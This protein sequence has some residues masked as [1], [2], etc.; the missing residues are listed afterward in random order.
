MSSLS[1]TSCLSLFLTILLPAGIRAQSQF[2]RDDSLVENRAYY[3]A[4]S[5]YHAYL[6]PEPALYRGNR[7][8]EYAFQLAEGHPFYG[9]GKAHKGSAL[10][11]SIFYEDLTI[12]YDMVKDQ[13]VIPSPFGAYKLYLI[14]SKVDGFTIEDHSFIRLKD[15]LNPTAPRNGFYEQLYKGRISLLKKNKKVLRDDL[16]LSGVRQYI[17]SSLSYYIK[18]G[19]TYYSVHNKNTLSH[20]FKDRSKELNRFIRQNK[21]SVRKDL[22]NTLTKV[23]AWYD[24]QDLIH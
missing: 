12:L 13:V 8:H 14:N 10:Y 4:V 23:S 7:Y 18:K 24:A 3:N 5:Q 2:S 15:S 19:D 9:D 16:Q 17:D 11:D 1:Q 21:L 22:E 6:K 20:A